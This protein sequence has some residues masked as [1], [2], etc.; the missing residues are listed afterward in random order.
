MDD[1]PPVHELAGA[2]FRAISEPAVPGTMVL[3]V[4]GDADL[5][6]APRLREGLSELVESG[7]TTVVVD[8]SDTTFVDSM[9][10]GVLLGAGKRLRA[11]GRALELVV[12]RPDIRRIFEITTLDRVFPLYATRAQ[13]LAGAGTDDG[14]ARD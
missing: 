13:A 14:S 7:V 10:L 8:L 9:A 12:T 6:T 4:I 1:G 11:E 2:E 5:H 3:R